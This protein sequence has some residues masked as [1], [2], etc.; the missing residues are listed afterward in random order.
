MEKI[1]YYI[2][3]SKSLFNV[4]CKTISVIP[5]VSL[6]FNLSIQIKYIR[7]STVVFLNTIEVLF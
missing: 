1:Q 5:K 4:S 7:N 2:S 3:F 6:F